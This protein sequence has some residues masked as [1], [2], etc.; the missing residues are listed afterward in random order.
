MLRRVIAAAGIFVTAVIGVVLAGWW[1]HRVPLSLPPLSGPFPVGRA[2]FDW[3]DE[4][5]VDKL[6]AAKGATRE[7]TV[8]IWYPASIDTSST[9]SEYL[10]A[11]WRAA[12][13]RRQS[14]VLS[15]LLHDAS[16]VNP[17]SFDDAKVAPAQ[18]AFPVILMKPGIGALALDYTTLAE[19]LASDGY[20][21]VA[22]DSPYSTF[23]VVFQDGRVAERRRAGNAGESAPVAEQTKVANSILGTWVGDDRFVLDRL[24]QLNAS[25][26]FRE[27]LDL[28]EVG[29]IGHSFGGATAAEFCREDS[30][31]KAGI[32]IDGIPFGA[33]VHERLERPFMFFL[34]DHSNEKRD[35]ETPAI[36]GKFHDI[37][38][39]L[40]AGREMVTL[41]GSSHFSFSDMPFLFNH[42]L[43]RVSGLLGSIEPTRALDAS[44]ACIRTFFDVHLK[45]APTSRLQELRTRY[46]ELVFSDAGAPFL[47]Q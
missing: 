6:A 35:P 40:P 30:R 31:C 10:P 17:R 36:M 24:A 26:T 4:S 34:S 25:G 27:R 23:V 16:A 19:D 28:R 8:W 37:Y 39:R 42:T 12:L 33:V 47:G 5:R 11:P 22:S 38:R 32:D 45:G 20:V 7:L 1:E 21:V 18:R 14:P 29:A 15:L 41:R 44:D 43:A 9:R 3:V 46:P 2:A 13:A